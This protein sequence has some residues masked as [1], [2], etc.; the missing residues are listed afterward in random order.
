M[1]KKSRFYMLAAMSLLLVACGSRPSVKAA[2]AP[3]PAVATIDGR[4]PARVAVYVPPEVAE[5]STQFIY[6]YHTFWIPEGML[7]AESALR[8][9]SERFES[10]KFAEQTTEADIVVKVRGNSTLNPLMGRYYVDAFGECYSA[11]GEPLGKFKASGENNASYGYSPVFE[12]TYSEAFQAV[13]EQMLGSE[14]CMSP[15][16]K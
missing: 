2:S 3:K 6:Y 13:V 11:K 16:K 4:V 1:I 10:A 12:R 9:F 7:I 15:V 8:A 14:Q 5:K